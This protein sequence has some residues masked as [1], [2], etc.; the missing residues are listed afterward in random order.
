MALTAANRKCESMGKEPE[1]T[2]TTTEFVGEN[3][4]VL[5]VTFKCK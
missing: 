4:V 3:S 2:S 1:V 5:T